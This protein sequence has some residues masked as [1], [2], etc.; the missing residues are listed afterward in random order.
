MNPF[1]DIKKFQ[2]H[3]HLDFHT[4]PYIPDVGADFD[5]D[6][7]AQTFAD[8][9]VQSVTIFAKCHHGMCYYPTKTGVRHPNLKRH[10]LMGDMIEALHRKGIRAPIYTTVAWEEDVASRFPQWR[11]MRA[12]GRFTQSGATANPQPGPWRYNNFIHLDYQDYIEAHVRELLENYPI[13]GL[14]FD[15]LFFDR[16]CCWSEASV[17]F[18]E[19]HGLMGSDDESFHRFQSAAQQEFA[20]RFTHLIHDRHPS[21]GVFYNMPSVLTVDHKI[22]TAGVSSLRTHWEIESLPSGFWGYYHFPRLARM[23]M[24]SDEPWIGQTGRFQRMWGDFGGIKPQ[25]ALEFEC[26]RAQAMGGLNGVG[27]QLHP[28]GTLDAAAYQLVGSVYSQWETAEPFYAGTK[29][30]P[31]VGI[32]VASGPSMDLS[33]EGAVQMCEESH[34]D[35]VVLNDASELDGLDLLILPDSSVMTEAMTSK[36]RAF[37]KNGGK[38]I[39]SHRAGFD[40]GGKWTLAN[41]IPLSFHGDEPLYPSY[42]RARPEFSKTLSISNRVMYEQGLKVKGP[43]NSQ[44]LID[45]VLPYFK[46]TDMKFCSHFQT[47][48]SPEID[49]QHAAVIGGDRWVYFADPIFREYRKSGNLAARDAWKSAMEKLIGPPPFGH[50]LPTTILLYPRRADRDL[51]LTLL[52]YVP[53]RKSL[54]IDVVEER[55]SFA[56]EI[57]HLPEAAKQVVRFDTNESLQRTN[58]GGF[59]LPITKG[60]LLLNVPGFFDR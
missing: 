29:S 7:F 44:V 39:A 5:P 45:R 9:K 4:S 13:D 14:F 11:Q 10:D 36:I 2:R 56:G 41:E 54:E 15:I 18:R 40:A 46:R 21:A 58:D 19:K 52:H 24:Q 17:A 35:A 42:W 32:V 49:R 57:L 50:G 55:M 60:R 51:R 8:A 22:G 28:R 59:A 27:D 53:L 12:D 26:F 48:A 1:H 25:A 23:A 38:L 33:L 6:V 34:Y 16:Q 43:E 20:T 30:I 37:A 31:Q 47:P 3:I